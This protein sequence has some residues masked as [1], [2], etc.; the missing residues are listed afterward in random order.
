MKACGRDRRSVPI[1]LPI[2]NGL[3]AHLT[4]LEDLSKLNQCFLREVMRWASANH[5]H[6]RDYLDQRAL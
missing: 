4:R 5:H 6:T 3:R 2:R 1:L